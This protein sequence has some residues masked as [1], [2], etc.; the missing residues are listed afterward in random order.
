[1]HRVQSNR[2]SKL[3]IALLVAFVLLFILQGAMNN[4]TLVSARTIKLVRNDNF[5]TDKIGKVPQDPLK[6]DKIPDTNRFATVSNVPTAQGPV[7]SLNAIISPTTAFA[8]EAILELVV[9]ARDENG[10]LATDYRGSIEFVESAPATLPS[11]SGSLSNIPDYTF[12]ATDAGRATFTF[13]FNTSGVHNVYIY[14]WADST[15]NVT[16]NDVTVEG[17]FLSA[18]ISPTMAMAGESILTLVVEAQDGNGNVWSGYRGSIEFVESAPSTLPS[19]SG[20]LKNKPDYTFTAADAGQA[21]F[22]FA[23]NTSGIHN[24]YIYDWADSANRNTTTND[25]TVEEVF[26]SAT[27]SPT[28]AMAGESVLTLVVEAKDGN[29]NIWPSYR[30]SIEFVESAPSTLPSISGSL[31]NKPDYTFTA[32]DA[33]HTTF[34]FAFNTSGIHN[35]YI[36]DWA[37]SANRNTTTNNVEIAEVYLT[38]FISPTIGI[39]KDRVFTLTVE[40]RDQSGAIWPGYRGGIEIEPSVSATGLPENDPTFGN[41]PDYVFTESD[42]GRA[43]FPNFSF[44]EIGIQNVYVYELATSSRNATTNDVT[45]TAPPPPTPAPA[46]PPPISYHVSPTLMRDLPAPFVYHWGLPFIAYDDYLGG[47]TWRGYPDHAIPTSEGAL[48]LVAGRT[49][50]RS[51]GPLSTVFYACP[52]LGWENPMTSERGSGGGL[53]GGPSGENKLP[54]TIGFGFSDCSWPWGT[55]ASRI[56]LSLADPAPAN[57]E[58][59]HL[60]ILGGGNS[61]GYVSFSASADSVGNECDVPQESVFVGDPIDTRSG[62]FFINEQDFGVETGCQGI[63]L[64]FERSYSSISLNEST[65]GYGW[66]HNYNQEIIAG[67]SLIFFLKNQ[68]RIVTLKKRQFDAMGR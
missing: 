54:S 29:G 28:V 4:T 49:Q 46:A 21:T 38:A 45:V 67:R 63:D 56:N 7:A 44:N 42:A 68:I 16:T 22:T 37:D 9:E 32:A 5:A 23:F 52:F 25:V 17:V 36:Y 35:V 14:D 2:W 62:A 18:T 15:R 1:M 24:V 11:L 12:T 41:N 33:G 8:G 26:L 40:A 48:Y 31:K 59:V 43:V 3:L 58:G 47:N 57:A 20:S 6:F 60:D 53:D 51:A 30:G 13:A 61:A 55:G 50:W 34:T 19:I 64:R 66:T 10:D 39:A 65:F 27:I